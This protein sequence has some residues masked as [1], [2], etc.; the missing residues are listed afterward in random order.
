MKLK[1]IGLAA[2]LACS[3]TAVWAQAGAKD[4]S[5]PDSGSEAGQLPPGGSSSGAS[6]TTGHAAGTTGRAKAPDNN[7][8]SAH[9]TTGSMNNNNAPSTGTG[10]SGSSSNLG[11][12]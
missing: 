4:G 6:G 1:T 10:N 8:P 11:R 3:G 2:V 7:L 5:R 9:D 12:H